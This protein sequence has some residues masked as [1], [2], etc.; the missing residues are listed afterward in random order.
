M[1]FLS[2][3]RVITT[4]VTVVISLLFV[5][6]PNTSAPAVTSPTVYCGGPAAYPPD[7]AT[8][9]DP[10]VEAQII[11]QQR[12]DAAASAAAS[13]AAVA[14][15]KA[16]DEAAASA[17]KAQQD[18]ELQDAIALS[19]TQ[20][21]NAADFAK[22]AKDAEDLAIAAKDAEDIAITAANDAKT[23]ED[24]ARTAFNN[25]KIAVPNFKL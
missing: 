20:A 25:A 16:A 21:K 2:R 8:C 18:K 17:L 12:A 7:I 6:L 9:V 4:V 5:Q 1:R 23:A 10:V 11:A 3:H 22:A 14:R 13:A 24:N 15:Q 19:V